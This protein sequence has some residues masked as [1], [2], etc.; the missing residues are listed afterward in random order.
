VPA[1]DPIARIEQVARDLGR[2]AQDIEDYAGPD[3][4]KV[5]VH[6]QSELRAA[7]EGIR[8]ATGSDERSATGSQ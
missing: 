6:W 2:L 3:A 1:Q 5:L 8:R 7:L 4:R